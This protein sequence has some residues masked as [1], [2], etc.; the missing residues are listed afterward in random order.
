V[1]LHGDDDSGPA[2]H[3]FVQDCDVCCR[4]IS[5]RARLGAD[6]EIEADFERE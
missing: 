3:S 2:A 6:G 5:V 1:D 4:P